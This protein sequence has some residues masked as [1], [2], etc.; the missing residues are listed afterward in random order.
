MPAAD[1]VRVTVRVSAKQL[2]LLLVCLAFTAIGVVM[3][4][5][6]DLSVGD[7]IWVVLDFVLFGLGGLVLAVQTFG[8]RPVL[9]LDAHG[10]R[11]PRPW[12]RSGERSL[13]WPEVSGIVATR[14]P[15]GR[16]GQYEYLMFIPNTSEAPSRFERL[17]ADFAGAPDDRASRYLVMVRSWNL[18]ID[19]VVQAARGYR[20]A[21]EFIDHR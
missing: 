8:A 2:L 18:S 5:V 13:S 11:L 1:S 16:G 10:V 19:E 3:L 12:P 17:N 7:L 15:T 6:G 9:V 14:M 21:L 4:L 20:P